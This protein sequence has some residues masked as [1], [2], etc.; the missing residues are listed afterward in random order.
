MA[1]H[2][3]MGP[4]GVDVDIRTGRPMVRQPNVAQDKARARFSHAVESAMGISADLHQ[5]NSVLKIFL[6]Q[7][8]NR[9]ADLAKEDPVCRA[10]EAPIRALRDKLEVAPV[11]AEREALRILGPNLAA[12]TEETQET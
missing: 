11:L 5:N 6:E 12:L 3:I 1:S 8:R 10:L 4:S 9:L 2:R 7:Y